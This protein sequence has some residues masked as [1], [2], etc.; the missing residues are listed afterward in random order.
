M[1]FIY[2]DESGQFAKHNDDQYFILVTFTVGEPKRTKKDFRT[3]QHKKFPRK[4]KYQAEVKFSDVSDEELKVKMLKHIANMDVRIRYTYLLRNNIPTI[5]RDKKSL[6][7]GHLYTEVVCQTLDMY[8]PINE[9]EF[10][11]FCDRRN[12]K[13]ITQSE[14]KDTLRKNLTKA[15]PKDSIIQIETVDSTTSEN[16]QIA[17]WIAG[18]LASYHN[19]KPNGEEYYTIL[20]NNLI[21]DG[22]ELF[23]S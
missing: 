11:L 21:G 15:M 19:K 6:K 18:A 10:R 17:D 12:L 23:A 14:F 20:R 16:I 13:G 8:L 9:K 22:K 1:A 4:M 2:L 5:F 3:F 7:S